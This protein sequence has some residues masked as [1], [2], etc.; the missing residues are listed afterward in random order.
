MGMNMR[1]QIAALRTRDAIIKLVNNAI[2]QKRPTDR[3]GTVTEINYDNRT[4]KVRFPGDPIDVTV[5]LGSIWPRNIGQVVRVGG[6][7][8]SQWLVDVLGA[9]ALAATPSED[10][11]APEGLEA[12]SMALAIHAQWQPVAFGWMYE[13]EAAEDDQFTLNA[14]AFKTPNTHYSIEGITAGTE[15]WLRVRTTDGDSASEWSTPISVVGEH[16]PPSP[17]LTDGLP[18]VESPPVMVYGFLGGVMAEW[19]PVDNPDQVMYEVHAD[20][21]SGFTPTEDTKLGVTSGT[22]A[23]VNNVR[24]TKIPGGTM[25]FVRVVAF[26]ADGAAPAG[27]QGFAEAA[28]IDM[29]DAGN[30]HTSWFSDGEVPAASPSDIRAEGGPGFI[31]LNWDHIDNADAVTYEVHVG[32]HSDFLPVEGTKVLET[33]SNFA[34]VK[35]LP[36]SMG[37]GA[38]Q[39]ETT[40]HII[41]FAKD[42][43]GYAD[44]PSA[45]VTAQL[46]RV[47]TTDIQDGAVTSV[48]LADAAIVR[49]KIADAAIGSAQIGSA[50]ITEAKIASASISSAKI[51]D[52]AIHTAKIADLAVDS[53]KIANLSVNTAKISDL[54]VTGAK[55]GNAAITTAKIQDA[56]ITTAKIGN[57]QIET[58][59][60]KNAAITNALIEDS[61][62]TN[63][64]IANGTIT[65]AEIANGTIMAAKIGDAQ[66][67]SAKI[68]NLSVENIHIANNAVGGPQIQDVSI[69]TTKISDGAITTAKIGNAQI[70]DAKIANISADKINAGT[71]SANR[72]D[73]GVITG[74]E[75]SGVTI[76]G[77]V[78]RTAA[79]GARMEIASSGGNAHRIQFFNPSGGVV[80]RLI[81]ADTGGPL[82]SENGFSSTLMPSR[83][84]Q[85]RAGTNTLTPS[86][87]YTINGAT[88]TGFGTNGNINQPAIFSNN[89]VVWR[90]DPAGQYFL[91]KMFAPNMT[92]S[93]AGGLEVRRYSDSAGELFAYS[94][95][96]AL[97]GNIKP[98]GSMKAGLLGT[99]VKEWDSLA[100]VPPPDESVEVDL[101]EVGGLT[102]LR[103]LVMGGPTVKEVDPDHLPENKGT[104]WARPGFIA[105]DCVTTWPEI[106]LF[107]EEGN[108][109]GIDTTQVLF[110]LVQYAQEVES[111]LQA[112]EQNAP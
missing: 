105:E 36:P 78:F 75:I 50:A 74:V 98:A 28:T 51:Q 69:G 88:T 22:F 11:V 104:V 81:N 58:A 21:E 68:A 80:N 90:S 39:Y 110:A 10:L 86:I 91:N 66:I 35:N 54:A 19:A 87:A 76:T 84:L 92:I 2:D 71:M 16:F 72:I 43:D 41:V 34:F 57:A 94:S 33:P 9:A 61:A 73:G 77:G 5:K 15:Y 95:T 99:A 30:I 97:K 38:L 6:Y 85:V 53:A 7:A 17:N 82:E 65:N 107:D 67:T 62:I 56:A 59:H 89:T 13:V 26:D 49:A 31:S 108:P 64:K 79:G 8:G 44:W 4:A 96:S 23:S 1:D 106:V 20:W 27:P 52:A 83:L 48:T 14:I 112:L 100:A 103:G 46:V 102:G 12:T 111:R 3:T 24:G 29:G 47:G 40:Y 63:A 37:G 32:G 70:T 101:D 55:I 42:I 45:S 25:V 109:V 60:I 18:P 93:T